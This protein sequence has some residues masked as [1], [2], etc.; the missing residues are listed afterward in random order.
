MGRETLLALI[1]AGVIF[2]IFY[3]RF[4]AWGPNEEKVN[5]GAVPRHYTT[6]GL[7]VRYGMLY[8]LS[9]ELI[10]GF[11]LYFPDVAHELINL[12]AQKELFKLEG[13]DKKTFFENVALWGTIIIVAI[14]PNLPKWCN[15]D[16]VLRKYFHKKAFITSQATSIVE[17]LAHRFETFEADKNILAEVI[18]Q[19][20]VAMIP[21]DFQLQ[22]NNLKH[23]WAK[24]CY[25]EHQFKHWQGWRDISRFMEG[26][27]KD[28]KELE[29]QLK[30]LKENYVAY[31]NYTNDIKTSAKKQNGPLLEMLENE[32]QGKI[33]GLLKAYYS[34]ISCGILATYKIPSKRQTAFAHFG[35]KPRT[36]ATVPIDIDTILKITGVVLLSTLVPAIVYFS[37]VDPALL[38]AKNVPYPKDYIDASVWSLLSL[39]LQGGAVFISIFINNLWLKYQN[40]EDLGFSGQ[41]HF[42]K[43]SLLRRT[44]CALA[45]YLIGLLV[46]S[47]FVFLTN[48]L[49]PEVFAKLLPWPLLSAVTGYF[50]AYYLG[51]V[52]NKQALHSK[53]DLW[54]SGL[55]Q[56]IV[57]TVFGVFAVMLFF[58]R[59]I[60]LEEMPFLVFVASITFI[61]GMGIGYIFPEGF[62]KL[63]NELSRRDGQRFDI[64]EQAQ[65]STE[66]ATI[67]C[68]ITNI[69]E[70]GAE[71]DK[72]IPIHHHI[73]QISSDKLGDITGKVVR[74]E[75]SKTYIQFMHDRNTKE[76]VQGFIQTLMAA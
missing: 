68:M 39:F 33:D 3:A 75:M 52:K 43:P 64:T 44:T 49:S 13:F 7:Y 46:L 23:K 71:L 66:Q 27:K 24:L 29:Q 26:Y 5:S 32:L 37:L 76:R 25:L 2:I 60:G 1:G 36:N 53:A 18:E 28:R 19:T 11:I 17:D 73:V 61:I 14:I 70:S 67:A 9:Y 58:N 57:S 47:G 48:K 41:N 31:I 12:A 55:K 63:R 30:K 59:K 65:I 16:Y 74:T 8:A 15:L 42:L 45:S 69:S 51:A 40:S 21:E 20:P 4:N 56:A 54:K 6:W 62:C 72:P 34:I 50:I 35:L 22:I 38:E 10:F